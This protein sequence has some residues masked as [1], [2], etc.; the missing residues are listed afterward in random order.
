MADSPLFHRVTIIGLGLIGGSLGRALRER[1]LVE[2]IVGYDNNSAVTAAALMIGAVDAG[3]A[4]L[5]KAVEDS[6]VI[7]LCTP[8]ST[9]RDIFDAI[10]PHLKPGAI[11]TDVGSVKG[12]IMQEVAD[13]LP[14][15]CSFV[16][17]HPIAGSERS[18]PEAG[19]ADMFKGKQ[20]ILTPENENNLAV[21]RVKKLW[22]A[23]GGK[24]ECCDAAFHDGVF[25]ITSHVPHLLAFASVTLI[26]KKLKKKPDGLNSQFHR[27]IRL[28]ASNP[29]MWTDIFLYN[30]TDLLDALEGFCAMLGD[31][32]QHASDTK[33]LKKW[34]KAPSQFRRDACKTPDKEWDV[35]TDENTYT[36]L[37][38]LLVAYAF[39]DE[40]AEIE[41][42]Q[43]V[44]LHHYLGGGF[45]DVTR[46]AATPPEIGA[47]YIAA[48]AKDAE[49]CI[50][51]MLKEVERWM[52]AIRKGDAE[53]L[54]KYITAAGE[55]THHIREIIGMP[56]A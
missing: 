55:H 52:K 13:V 7:V 56:A 39:S 35:L 33:A 34:L 12:Q 4:E 46:P 9:T 6:D 10:A 32:R 47:A 53:A 51:A 29:F 54:D 50:D 26:G 43:E 18:G 40:V 19:S 14:P 21:K 17:G 15:K 44:P 22:E 25:G 48:H 30:A 49:I 2:D 3:C 38:P 37:L 8:L 27:F 45:M 20:V 36:A 41:K 42:E 16:P 28:G 31:L 5:A 23:I 11:V 24:V 1:R